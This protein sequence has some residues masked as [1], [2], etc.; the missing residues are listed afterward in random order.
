MPS[1][2]LSHSSET[3][4]ATDEQIGSLI[5]ERAKPIKRRAEQNLGYFPQS[6]SSAELVYIH[7]DCF[8]FSTGNT[9]VMAQSNNVLRITEEVLEKEFGLKLVREEENGDSE[10][11]QEFGTRIPNLV[12]I[13]TERTRDG[14]LLSL[15][16]S[17][18][19]VGGEVR[20]PKPNLAQ[21]LKKRIP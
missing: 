8:H 16:W 10:H 3:S 18:R 7:E 20:V 21:V 1:P 11:T 9:I 19:D 12:F 4:I 5:L 2:E 13:R 6:E 17:A 14:K 15:T